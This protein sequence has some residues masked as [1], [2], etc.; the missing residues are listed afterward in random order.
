[1]PAEDETRTDILLVDDASNEASL[2][3]ASHS[4]DD[5]LYEKK[6]WG[7]MRNVLV[8]SKTPQVTN[9]VDAISEEVK[10]LQ[11][12]RCEKVIS[13]NF[14]AQNNIKENTGDVT[15][16][17]AVKNPALLES[18]PERELHEEFLRRCVD[19]L[20]N[21]AVFDGTN[22]NNRVV[23]WHPPE[24]LRQLLNFELHSAP[25]SHE[26]LETL[27]QKVVR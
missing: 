26:E 17:E 27:V 11:V 4:E 24:E 16:K 23:E 3:E 5:D 7:Q 1:M 10:K 8:G 9:F 18:Q 21:E 13:E 20:L 14:A 12:S 22:R 25:A 6:P 15:S 2:S 19:I